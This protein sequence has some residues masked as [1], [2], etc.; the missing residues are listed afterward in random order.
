MTYIHIYVA[1]KLCIFI[2]TIV[3]DNVLLVVNWYGIGDTNIYL[4]H[5]TYQCMFC[6]GCNITLSMYSG[7]YIQ[8]IYIHNLQW[9]SKYSGTHCYIKES[10]VASLCTGAT[11]LYGHV[12][13]K[14]VQYIVMCLMILLI[15]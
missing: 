10:L 14:G 9:T 12:A 7:L 11:K 1:F 2:V 3:T 15:P 5:E 4:L 8:F 13:H 6:N